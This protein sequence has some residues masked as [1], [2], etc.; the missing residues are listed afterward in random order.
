M[1][2]EDEEVVEHGQWRGDGLEEG[3][4]WVSIVLIFGLHL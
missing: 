4:V 3:V 2:G 1:L